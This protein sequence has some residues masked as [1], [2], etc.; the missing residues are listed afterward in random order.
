[1]PAALQVHGHMHSTSCSA[2]TRLSGLKAEDA[3]VDQAHEGRCKSSPPPQLQ[4]AEMHTQLEASRQEVAKL[5]ATLKAPAVQRDEAFPQ[6]QAQKRLA[7]ES[8]QVAEIS[9]HNAS[10]G[11]ELLKEWKC[12]VAE[13]KEQ[14]KV[15]AQGHPRGGTHVLNSSHA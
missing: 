15:R 5:Q 14:L 6:Y 9:Q 10:S 7:A 2:D 12:V 4:L 11:W 8:D 1:L 13:L 3:G